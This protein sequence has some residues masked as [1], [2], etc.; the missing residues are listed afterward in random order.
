M[1]VDE[2]YRTMA[3]EDMAYLLQ[4]QPG[5]FSFVGSANPA[6][7]L[8]AKHHQ[9][10]FDFDEGALVKG[11]ALMVGSALNLLET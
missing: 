2:N 3:S 10:T 8:D 5:C 11:T 1:E 6:R 4:E 9:S 7:G